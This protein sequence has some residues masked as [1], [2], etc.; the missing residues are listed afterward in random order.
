MVQRKKSP[1][2]AKTLQPYHRICLS[3][4]N[5]D[6]SAK[7]RPGALQLPSPEEF[8]IYTFLS[9]W[10]LLGV[11]PEEFLLIETSKNLFSRLPTT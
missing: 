1:K 4:Q 9:F 8:L 10:V 7:I 3:H 2:Q 11:L 5:S 6:T